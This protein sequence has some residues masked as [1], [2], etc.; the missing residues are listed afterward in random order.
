[1]IWLSPPVFADAAR[2]PEGAGHYPAVGLYVGDDGL[3]GTVTRPD[4]VADAG[5]LHPAC[6]LVCVELP[7]RGVPD[8][9][10]P[11]ARAWVEAA[12]AVLKAT[13]YARHGHWEEFGK[14]LDAAHFHERSVLPADGLRDVVYAAGRTAGAWGGRGGDGFVAFVCPPEKAGA[15]RAAALAAAQQGKGPC[16]SA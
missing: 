4:G 13:L 14:A 9:A 16:P 11:D 5:P 3:W 10:R 6:P 12:G 15:V 8:D 7:C 1:M 2:R